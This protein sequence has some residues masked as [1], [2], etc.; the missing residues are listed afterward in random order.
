MIQRIFLSLSFTKDKGLQPTYLA[1]NNL[2]IKQ[3]MKIAKKRKKKTRGQK[4]KKRQKERKKS[5]S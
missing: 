4:K 3:N 1:R 5:G 2:G